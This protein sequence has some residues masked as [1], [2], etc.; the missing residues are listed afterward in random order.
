MFDHKIASGIVGAELVLCVMGAVWA[1]GKTQY[2]KGR[3]SA[4]D[5]M[6]EALYEI[7]ENIK[8]EENNF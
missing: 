6:M 1:Y 4:R 3:I 5:E 8:R 7:K 2:Y